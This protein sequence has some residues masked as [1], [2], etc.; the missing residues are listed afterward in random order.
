MTEKSR[1]GRSRIHL[2]PGYHAFNVVLVGVTTLHCHADLSR[3]EV[4]GTWGV[5]RL[6]TLFWF[7]LSILGPGSG[8]RTQQGQEQSVEKE[9]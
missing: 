9:T 7:I 6:I 1:Q 2:L 4:A 5:N 8:G 3:M